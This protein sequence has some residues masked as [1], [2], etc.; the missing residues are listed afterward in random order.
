ML[1]DPA[2]QERA[3]ISTSHTGG[4]NSGQLQVTVPATVEVARDIPGSI[5]SLLPMRVSE[6]LSIGD[7]RARFLEECAPGTRDAETKI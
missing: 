4:G 6:C 3:A 7:L 1:C 2:A 5:L